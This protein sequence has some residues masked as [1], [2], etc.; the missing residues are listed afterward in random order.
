MAAKAGG[1]SKNA[2]ARS[3]HEWRVWVDDERGDRERD[4][5]RHAAIRGMQ[6][7]HP[8]LPRQE[9]RQ[10][11]HPELQQ[12]QGQ[13]TAQQRGVQQIGHQEIKTEPERG[14]GREL[15]V[16]AADPAAG[17]EAERKRQHDG[18]GADVPQHIG[19][20]HADRERQQEEPADQDQR[21]PVRDRHGKQIARCRE[22]HHRREH[23]QLG[24]VRD[25]CSTVLCGIGGKS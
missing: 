5:V 12:Q 24:N 6:P 9:R 16:A 17:E 10:R 13:C 19:G 22:R 25:H 15:G 18:G 20:L 14:R 23:Q 8:V 21:D 7:L 1:R 4:A 11:R 2:A 3:R